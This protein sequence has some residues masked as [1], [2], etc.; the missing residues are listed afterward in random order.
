MITKHDDLLG[1][2]IHDVA[3]LL[4]LD[5]DRRVAPHNL[6]RTKWLALGV[7]HHNPGLSQAVLASELELGAAAVGKLV[8]RLEDRGFV[9]RTSAPGD[10][11]ARTLS[12]TPIAEKLV[13]EL[14]ATTHEL[15]E[16]VLDGLSEREVKL[17]NQGLNKLKKNLQRA[18][19]SVCSVLPVRF[20]AFY[21]AQPAIQF[22]STL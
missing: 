21:E 3:H 6:T 14:D 22:I 4:R 7:I 15:K 11:R 9:M 2:L 12:L 16:D 10:R 13:T 20:D 1:T 8:D 17:L 18:A 5:I 19:L